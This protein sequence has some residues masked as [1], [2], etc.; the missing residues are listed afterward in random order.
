MNPPWKGTGAACARPV[1][2][3]ESRFRRLIVN[4]TVGGGIVMDEGYLGRV[5]ALFADA[6]ALDAGDRGAFLDR[7]CRGEPALR[8]DVD[9]LLRLAFQPATYLERSVVASGLLPDALAS[10][11]AF[12]TDLEPGQR[13]GSWR[14]V[15][16]VGRGGM[17]TVFLV[18]RV[19]GQ[20]EQRGALK[21]VRSMAGSDDIPRRLQR[22][23]RILA[24]LTHPGIARLLDG[25]QTEDGRP[26]FVMEFVEGF[27]I[28]RY[29]DDRRLTID[30][31]L[32]LFL[33]VC[34]AVQHAHRQLVVHRD[35][36]PSNIIVT[37]D[38]DVKLLDFGI[39]KLLSPGDKRDDDAVTSPVIR[40]L[41]PEYASPEQVRNEPVAIASDVYQLG[42]L[43]YE[44][45]TGHRAQIAAMLG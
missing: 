24:S 27:P 37:T 17:A 18:D 12:E 20:F 43:L 41:T 34:E 4:G 40:I 19:E 5:D 7:R 28:D 45:L 32:D 38:G 30:D 42:L 16:E 6:L 14:V 10:A 1:A 21:L 8:A 2:L 13:I 33:R 23:R 15:R 39:A 35:I 29:C 3:E 26:F 31:R 25:G 22:E 44:L 11:R 36:K 9:E